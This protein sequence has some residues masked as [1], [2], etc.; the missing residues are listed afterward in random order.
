MRLTDSLKTRGAEDRHI[1]PGAFFSRFVSCVCSGVQTLAVPQSFP[2]DQCH[3]PRNVHA[4]VASVWFVHYP[5]SQFMSGCRTSEFCTAF[6]GN[7]QFH[8]FPVSCKTDQ[9]ILIF[10]SKDFVLNM[11][12][13]FEPFSPQYSCISPAHILCIHTPKTDHLFPG[14]FAY[15]VRS[16]QGQRVL[17]S[18][19]PRC[20]PSRYTWC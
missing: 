2:S 3:A 20:F 7:I 5:H 1:S 16:S 14:Q 12:F 11:H 8:M 15:P 10:S 4:Y 17:G 6:I 13:E 18:Q 9:K 19:R